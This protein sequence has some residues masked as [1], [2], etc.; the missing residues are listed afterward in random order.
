LRSVPPLLVVL[1][2][3]CW[4]PSAAAQSETAD[5]ASAGPLEHIYLSPEL[6]CQ[7]KYRGDATNSFYG[8]IPGSCYTGL[9]VDGTTYRGTAVSQSEVTGS[10]TSANPFQVVTQADA[11]T[12]GLRMTQT[13]RYVVGDDFYTTTVSV[14]STLST[15]TAAILWHASDCYL[16]DSDV[17]FGY[18]DVQTN[19]I[20]CTANAN[21][22]PPARIEGFV[23]MTAGAHWFEGYYGSAISP[24]ATGFADTCDCTVS[25]DNGA[26]LSWNVN[27]PAG[28]TAAVSFATTFSPTGILFDESPPDTMPVSG[29]AGMIDSKSA[30]FAFGASEAG[31]TFECS[32][33]GGAFTPCSSPY[34]LS[35]LA[36]GPHTMRVRAADSNGNADPTPAEFTFSVAAQLEDLPA[37]K[38]GKQV[39]VEAVAGTVL[40]AIPAG[41]AAR[42]SGA[43][44]SQKGLR[45]VPLEEARQ[46]PTGSFLDTSRGTVQLVSATG[47]GQRTQDG[48]FTAGLFQV[49]QSRK[50]R[51]KGLTELRLK[52]GPS[53]AK[54]CRSVRHGKRASAS[55]LSSRTLRRLRANAHGRFRTRGTHS[56]ATVRGT[57]W[58][59]ADRCDGTLTK[60][61]R[62][63]VAVRDFRRKKTILVSAGKSYLAKARG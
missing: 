44:A 58:L 36:A 15:D 35:G 14:S 37:P 49:L 25:E 28:G 20:Y 5:I 1:V 42:G 26:G 61:T 55:K 11:G 10:G 40:V 59:M 2:L 12:T 8:G 57:A 19:A 18:H 41:G 21:N 23:P 34:T 56:A 52:G 13:D 47:A 3:C 60:V 29:P 22:S 38:V 45:F 43:R 9:I 24:P 16:Q 7:V 48:K 6:T 63:T 27:V 31:A 54:S 51:E 39:N 33:D 30:T 53:S 50:K 17:G 46:I 4:A 62:G 32:L